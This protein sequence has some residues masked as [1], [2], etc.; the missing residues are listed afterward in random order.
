MSIIQEIHSWSK[1]LPLWQQDAIARLYQNSDL[2]NDDLEDLYALAKSEVGISDD[3]KRVPSPIKDAE[4]A[5]PE[6]SARYVK[7][8]EIKNLD[9]VNA[10]VKD[11]SLP[12]AEDGMTVI[13]GENG[14]GKSG[15]TRIFKHACRARDRRE[16]ILPN[17]NLDPMER[18]MATAVF[19]TSVDGEKLEYKWQYGSES[20]EPLSDISIF[21]TDC[22]KAYIDN[23]GDFA[24]TP[25]GLSILETLVQIS[26]MIKDR[27]NADLLANKPDIRA[28]LN[29]FQENT[30]TSAKL[31]TLSHLTEHQ[32]I[33]ALCDL[34]QEEIERY[35]E[36]TTLLAEPE[37]KLK[38]AAIRQKVAR[39]VELNQRISRIVY[40]LDDEKVRNL[41]QAIQASN[42]AK[43]VAELASHAFLDNQAQLP[44]TG[45]DEWKALFN[46][47]RDFSQIAYH[48][49]DIANVAK[50]SPC[51]LCQNELGEAGA[52]RL[53]KFD[54]FIRQSTEKNAQKARDTAVSLYTLIRDL[55][56]NF[57]FE[58]AIY[59]EVKE[60]SEELSTAYSHLQQELTVRKNSIIIAVKEER[61]WDKVAKFNVTALEICKLQIEKL[62]LTAQ[63]LEQSS[64]ETVRASLANEKLVLEHRIKL[65]DIKAAILEAIDKHV[66]C[67]KLQNCLNSIDISK[68]SRKGTNLSRTLASQELAD[69]LNL[70]LKCLDV[71]NLQIVMRA[72]TSGGK[73]NYKLVL[74]M[75][76]NNTPSS[77]LSEGEQ[78]AISLASFLAELQLSKSKGGI[79]LDDPVSSLDHRRRWVIAQRLAQEARKRQVIVFTHDIYFLH[80]L[81]EMAK[82]SSTSLQTSYIRRTSQGYG[83]HSHELPFDILKTSSRIGQLKQM[84]IEIRRAHKAGDDEEQRTLTSKLYH[85]LR[86]AWER[87]VEEVLLN[88]VINRFGPNVSTL[89]LKSVQVTDDDYKTIEAGMTKS[90]KFEHDAASAIERLPVPHPDD[91]AKDIF[92]LEEW[93]DNVNRRLSETRKNRS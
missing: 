71:D 56:E 61:S 2:S 5:R 31:K 64:D 85:R 36:L 80:V 48:E 26:N 49:L 9:H 58:G 76:G 79:V 11:G 44:G 8:L 63:E 55:A 42:E 14:A 24:Y 3:K 43:K 51:L 60:V 66:L 70:E 57:A 39:I 28:L 33:D 40:S 4:L 67:H 6:L 10:L 21:D 45:G 72:S 18:G 29:V 54:E 23:H 62:L 20:P 77:I 16:P 47:A 75:P 34:S 35:T 86:L 83:V 17:A 90:S 1:E 13:Y 46:A 59:D 74:E 89:A 53:K 25:Y 41:K 12:I 92:E 50:E 73:T 52:A 22:A 93:R 15:Y 7:I 27:L 38:A 65:I 37:P 91:I 19:M 78:R 84:L 30:P 68:I 88:G 87:A 32:E 69:A 81:E 82:A